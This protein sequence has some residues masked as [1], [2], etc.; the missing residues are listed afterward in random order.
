MANKSSGV[1]GIG[2]KEE[3][4]DIMVGGKIDP[5]YRC[6]AN[7]LNRV[8][9]KKGSYEKTTVEGIWLKY[10]NFRGWFYDNNGVGKALDKDIIG[11]GTIYGPEHCCMVS[12]KLNNFLVG[13]KGKV[14]DEPYGTRV[15]KKGSWTYKAYVRNTLTGKREFL[16]SFGSVQEA[17]KRWRKRKAEIAIDIADQ[18]EDIRV[19]RALREKFSGRK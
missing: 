13:W 2:Y 16:G 18:L 15:K 5:A 8:T 4:T 14:Y 12:Q 3:D 10:E 17:Q 7:M 19:S 11:D 1:C 9:K 6:W